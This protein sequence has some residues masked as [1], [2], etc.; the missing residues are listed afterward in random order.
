MKLG[1]FLFFV[2]FNVM[3]CYKWR[4]ASPKEMRLLYIVLTDLMFVGIAVAAYVNE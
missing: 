1:T 4:V 2:I 3:L